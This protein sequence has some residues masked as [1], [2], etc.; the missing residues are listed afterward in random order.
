MTIHYMVVHTGHWLPGRKVLISPV[1]LGTP[2][3]ESKTFPLRLTQEQ[4]RNSPD[5]DT[6]QSVSRQHEVELSRYYR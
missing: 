5:I 4:I 2:D 3:W 1:A 6:K